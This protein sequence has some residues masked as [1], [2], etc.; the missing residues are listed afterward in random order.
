MNPSPTSAASGKRSTDP[1]KPS[2]RTPVQNWIARVRFWLGKLASFTSAYLDKVPFLGTFLRLRIVWVLTIFVIG[3]A[4]GITWGS[5]GTVKSR[6]SS[7]R[8]KAMSLALSAARQSL[9]K[10]ANEMNRL[11]A[12]GTDVPQRRSAR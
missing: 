5:Y 7:E 12:Q 8:L 2:V 1:S 4:A 10:V 11:E 6:T 9:D 3:V